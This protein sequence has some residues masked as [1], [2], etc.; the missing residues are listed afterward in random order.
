MLICLCQ[1]K[2]KFG[3]FILPQHPP[4]HPQGNVVELS[5]KCVAN[6][7]NIGWGIG[8]GS[9]DKFIECITL[10]FQ[11]IFLTVLSTIVATLTAQEVLMANVKLP[12]VLD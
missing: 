10:K 8:G 3:S 9:L 1:F 2:V 7:C 4:P 5:V 11:P 12:T 6:N